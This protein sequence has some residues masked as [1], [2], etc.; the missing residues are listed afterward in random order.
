MCNPSSSEEFESPPEWQYSFT[1]V[2]GLKDVL[3]LLPLEFLFFL[4]TAA[5]DGL[6]VAAKWRM[7][8][9]ASTLDVKLA[10]RLPNLP[11][12]SCCFFRASSYTR[13]L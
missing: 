10:R 13:T 2:M 7:L 1:C 3:D 8:C 5:S 12:V 11:M 4:E 9:T 6:A